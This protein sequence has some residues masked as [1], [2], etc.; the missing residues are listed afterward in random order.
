MFGRGR[1]EVDGRAEAGVG[2]VGG[3]CGVRGVEGGIE[4]R[5]GAW[6]GGL[7]GEME[8]Q[9]AAGGVAHGGYPSAVDD[10]VVGGLQ[11]GGEFVPAPRHG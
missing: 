2:F 7:R 1:V 3:A 9:R 6:R 10:D 8:G 4:G 5:D 11:E